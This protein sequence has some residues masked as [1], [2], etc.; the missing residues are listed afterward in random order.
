M[1]V[2]LLAWVWLVVGRLP[3][4]LLVVWRLP[5]VLLVVWRPLT[6]LLMVRQLTRVLV[7]VLGRLLW[8]A[9]LIIALMRI[10]LLTVAT[11]HRTCRAPAAACLHSVQMGANT[12]HILA[13][14]LST[15]DLSISNPPFKIANNRYTQCHT[16]QRNT[17]TTTAAFTDKTR[18]ESHPSSPPP[19]AH[20]DDVI[21]GLNDQ[22]ATTAISWRAEVKL[23]PCAQLPEAGS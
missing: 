23:D 18:Q 7:L 20:T 22:R 19:K 17:T 12:D 15:I 10:A 5:W 11:L 16:Q 1:H 6:R 9:L 4:V 13:V 14:P 8:V 2:R 21:Q 3:W